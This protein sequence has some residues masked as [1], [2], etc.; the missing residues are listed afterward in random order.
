MHLR[1]LTTLSALL[2]IATSALAEPDTATKAKARDMGLKGLTLYDNGDYAGALG[3]FDPAYAMYPA[4]TLGVYSARALAKLGRLTEAS[5]RYLQV[6]RMTL[7]KDASEQFRQAQTDAENE[8]AALI[9]RIPRLR[10]EV[11]GGGEQATTVSVDGKTVA[12]TDLTSGV[13]LNPGAHDVRGQRGQDVVSMNVALQEGE[14]KTVTLEFKSEAPPVEPPPPVAPVTPAT[15]P[16]PMAPL[17]DSF[18]ASGQDT[19][20]GKRTVGWVLLGIGGVG[21]GVGA[22][23]GLLASNKKTDLEKVCHPDVSHCPESARTEVDEYN[24]QRTVSTIGFIAGGV[25][26]AGGALLLLT[27]P[28]ARGNER[29][30]HVT[31]WVGVGSLGMRGRF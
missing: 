27:A 15:T 4:P 30:A 3:Q 22:V 9:Q 10:V 2:L 20:S 8:R 26:L 28:S 6:S 19:G 25:G 14:T 23:T 5:E 31:P 17:R 16:P 11:A 21:V 13:T 29:A 12:A 24:T 7:P 1:T 18:P